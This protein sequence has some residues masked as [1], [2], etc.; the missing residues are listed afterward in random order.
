MPSA[1]ESRSTQAAARALNIRP[2]LRYKWPQETLQALPTDPAE[3]AKVRQL[4]TANK[5]L[6][7]ELE[8]LK[9]LSPSLQYPANLVSRYQFIDQ[10]RVVYLVRLLYLMRV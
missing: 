3:A 10:Q 5:R 6:A 1:S 7:Q 2:K 8:I 9:K 4:R